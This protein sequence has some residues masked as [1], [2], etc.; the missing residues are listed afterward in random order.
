MR[1]FL[2]IIVNLS[3]PF[4]IFYLCDFLYRL[5]YTKVLKQQKKEI[6]KLDLKIIIRLI[7]IGLIL[8]TLFFGIRR[9]SLT[10][11]PRELKYKV[12]EYNFR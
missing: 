2:V 3:I 6:P 5:Y 10:P 11:E 1:I 4:L 8:L 12:K 7:V 9:L